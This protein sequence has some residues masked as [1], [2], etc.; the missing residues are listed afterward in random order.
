MVEDFTCLTVV[1][2]RDPPAT[3]L[4]LVQLKT[5]LAF[6]P[7]TT[8]HCEYRQL[9]QDLARTNSQMART[10][11]DAQQLVCYHRV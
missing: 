7:S 5:L 6:L 10:G 8:A 1:Q 11:K 2:P 9:F 4:K 3:I